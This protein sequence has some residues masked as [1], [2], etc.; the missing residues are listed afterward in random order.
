MMRDMIYRA[1]RR[2]ADIGFAVPAAADDEIERIGE[3][4]SRLE[5]LVVA[6]SALLDQVVVQVGATDDE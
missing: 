2:E 6:M 1:D 3:R 4:V 5:R